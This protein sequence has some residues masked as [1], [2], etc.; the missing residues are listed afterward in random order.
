MSKKNFSPR[1]IV[2]FCL[3][4]KPEGRMNQLTN[5]NALYFIFYRNAE[6]LSGVSF[7]QGMN[8][9][10]SIDKAMQYLFPLFLIVVY[11]W[12]FVNSDNGDLQLNMC[13]LC[14]ASPNITYRN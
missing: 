2:Q 8:A 4:N 6:C 5:F 3:R 1:I 13:P 11:L 7:P 10:S 9:D 12:Y 14:C